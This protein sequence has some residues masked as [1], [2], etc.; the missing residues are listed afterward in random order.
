MAETSTRLNAWEAITDAL[1]VTVSG[2]YWTD[3]A[4]VSVDP[5]DPD[6]A[7]GG[8][9]LVVAFGGEEFEAPTNMGYY[10]CSQ[11]IH[12][13]GYALKSGDYI[14]DLC[15]LLQDVRRV[16]TEVLA[17]DGAIPGASSVRLVASDMD[18][19]WLEFSGGLVHFRQTIV[20]NYRTRSNW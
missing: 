18:T 8:P 4:S 12:V 1:E 15:K 16:V 13:D 7:S 3:V 10:N 19:G 9:W 6:S 5:P 20:V 17:V 14:S 11:Y 2:G